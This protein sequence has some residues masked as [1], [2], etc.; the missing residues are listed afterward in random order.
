MLVFFFFVLAIFWCPWIFWKRCLY[1]WVI[2]TFFIIQKKST[3]EPLPHWFE[4][5]S[6]LPCVIVSK[7]YHPYE[8]G[9]YCLGGVAW[10]WWWLGGIYLSRRLLRKLSFLLA[11]FIAI[12]GNDFNFIIVANKPDVELLDRIKSPKSTLFCRIDICDLSL[13]GVEKVVLWI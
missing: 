8:T 7:I 2:L 4:C 13:F 5:F 11:V 10:W 12:R 9:S 3:L 6:F 1:F